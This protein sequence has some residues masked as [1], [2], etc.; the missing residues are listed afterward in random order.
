MAEKN[1]SIPLIDSQKPD[2]KVDKAPEKTPVND[3]AS[4]HEKQASTENLHD[5]SSVK[6]CVADLDALVEKW[7]DYMYT[8]TNVPKK[9]TKCFKLSNMNKKTKESRDLKDYDVE[10][11][12]SNV[13]FKQEETVFDSSKVSV[14]NSTSQT[15]LQTSFVNRT[16]QEQESSFKME[17]TTTQVCEF[18][19]DKGFKSNQSPGFS[20]LIPQD[21]ANVDAS[22]KRE[23]NLV[24][25]KN[26]VAKEEVTWKCDSKIRVKPHSTTH[27]SLVITE[28]ELDRTFKGVVYIKG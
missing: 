7:I 25:G 17:R 16:S 18:A 8:T 13:S 3:E 5:K 15:L 27:G 26:V 21:I 9:S 19:F 1:E 2:T 10:I 23:R 12:W 11:D 14:G 28:M 24:A 22:I 6:E 4:D 20:L